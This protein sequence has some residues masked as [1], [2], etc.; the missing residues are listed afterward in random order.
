MY[1]ANDL[2]PIMPGLDDTKAMRGHR[3]ACF[4]AV[5]RTLEV[6]R[7]GLKLL[8]KDHAVAGAVVMRLL[9]LGQIRHATLHK[10]ALDKPVR[11]AGGQHE[12]TLET[13]RTGLGFGMTQK[14]FAFA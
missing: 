12:Q 2:L 10:T 7:K 6:Q 11:G 9:A 4:F 3:L 5:G 8:D 14:D 1:P 13:G